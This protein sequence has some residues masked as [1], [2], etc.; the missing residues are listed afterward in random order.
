MSPKKLTVF[1][2]IAIAIVF[3]CLFMEDDYLDRMQKFFFFFFLRKKFVCM[4][5][6]K[7]I[8]LGTELVAPSIGIFV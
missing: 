6:K 8:R 4:I 7:R 2:I 3:I 1:P 5:K